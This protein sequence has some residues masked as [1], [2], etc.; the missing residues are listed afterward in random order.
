MCKTPE[1]FELLGGPQR[2]K[3]VFDLSKWCFLWF[4]DTSLKR[5]YKELDQALL[6]KHRTI[7]YYGESDCFWLGHLLLTCILLVI[8]LGVR[9]HVREDKNFQSRSIK[10]NLRK[11]KYV[12]VYDLLLNWRLLQHV[13]SQF[14]CLFSHFLT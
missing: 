14:L 5:P 13:H 9:N 4:W 11:N 10:L 7:L 6:Q 2:S 1:L 8:L 12:L 3:I